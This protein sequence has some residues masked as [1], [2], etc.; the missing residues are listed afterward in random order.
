MS[1]TETRYQSDEWNIRLFLNRVIKIRLS[2]LPDS[3]RIGCLPSAQR[4]VYLSLIIKYFHS[5]LP[6]LISLLAVGGTCRKPSN[7]QDMGFVSKGENNLPSLSYLFV[8]IF[9][10]ITINWGLIKK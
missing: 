9:T 4:S 7:F 5:P 10:E 2:K 1:A 3:Y 6:E 8:R